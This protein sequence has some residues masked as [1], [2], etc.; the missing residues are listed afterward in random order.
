MPL[1]FE[2]GVVTQITQ[3]MA[4]GRRGFRI[5]LHIIDPGEVGIVK[6]ARVRCMPAGVNHRAEGSANRGRGVVIIESDA[7]GVETLPAQGRAVQ[8]A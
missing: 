7:A 8:Q 5:G 2:D 6:H 4:D 1:A 3:H